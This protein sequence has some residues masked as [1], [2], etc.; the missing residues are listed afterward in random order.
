MGDRREFLKALAKGA[1]YAAP[2]IYT[3]STPREL[4]AI[5]TSGRY[6]DTRDSLNVQLQESSTPWS[7]S[8]LP[9]APWAAPAPWQGPFP[10]KPPSLPD[11]SDD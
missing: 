11:D 4:M 3:L 2:V 6:F 5:V 8:D 10:A 1:T 7:A 9:E